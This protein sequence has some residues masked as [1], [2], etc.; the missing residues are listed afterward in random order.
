MTELYSFACNSR[1]TD[2]CNDKVH[3]NDIAKDHYHQIY[4]PSE[5]FKIAILRKAV[6]DIITKGLSH[7]DREITNWPNSFVII[8]VID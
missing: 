1:M 3:E 5:N 2:N 7:S 4:D 8:Q 6:S